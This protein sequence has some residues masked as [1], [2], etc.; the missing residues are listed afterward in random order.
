MS[1]TS[2]IRRSRESMVVMCIDNTDFPA[3]LELR[4]LYQVLRDPKAES[5]GQLRIVDESG[6]AYLYPVTMFL[7]GVSFSSKKIREKP[8]RLFKRDPLLRAIRKNAV[9]KKASNG[10]TR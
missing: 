1:K 10:K 5:H 7:A 9:S 2:N 4:K 6:D 3:S 8:S